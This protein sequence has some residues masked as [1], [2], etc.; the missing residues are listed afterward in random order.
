VIKVNRAIMLALG[1]D[2]PYYSSRLPVAEG[3]R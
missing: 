1:T 3:K 2:L